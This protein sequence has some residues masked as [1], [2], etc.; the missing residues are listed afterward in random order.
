[1]WLRDNSIFNCFVD[2]SAFRQKDVKLQ[3]GND[4]SVKSLETVHSVLC[5]AHNQFLKR[6]KKYLLLKNLLKFVKKEEAAAEVLMLRRTRYL[7]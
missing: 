7:L 2:Y 1:M 5:N 3:D 6:R 4:K